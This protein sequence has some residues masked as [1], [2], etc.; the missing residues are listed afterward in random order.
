MTKAEVALTSSLLPVSVMG[1]I[2][3]IM[4]TTYPSPTLSC[5]FGKTKRSILAL[6][7]GHAD[8]S[9][10]LRK[11]LRLTGVS[12]GAGQRELARLSGAGIISRTLKN[13]QVHFQANSGCPI[14][15]DLK[16]IIMRTLGVAD[17]LRSLLEPLSRSIDAAAVYGSIAKGTETK[18]SDIDVL[19]VGDVAFTDVTGCLG[20]AQAILSREIN[21]CV[22]STA[23]FGRRISERDHFL[24]S[25]LKG[26]LIPLMGDFDELVRLA[27]ERMAA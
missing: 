19:I 2:V 10:H 24:S 20:P 7:Y 3:L 17:V 26:A 6:L 25:A 12:P 4:S 23:E 1:T 22:M 18:E 15:D 8:E 13:S 14:F 21:P 27:K 9:F 16:S 11:I 5:L